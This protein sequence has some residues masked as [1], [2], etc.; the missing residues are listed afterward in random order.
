LPEY[1]EIPDSKLDSIQVLEKY[2]VKLVRGGEINALIGDTGR[3]LEE[4]NSADAAHA[5]MMSKKLELDPGLSRH[6][7]NAGRR[8]Y[9]MKLDPNQYVTDISNERDGG[10]DVY[11]SNFFNIVVRRHDV[12]LGYADPSAASYSRMDK[13]VV[14]RSID[15]RDTF[16]DADHLAAFLIRYE[17]VL[18]TFRNSCY[19]ELQADSVGDSFVSP[20]V[21]RLAGKYAETLAS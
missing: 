11:A 9:R 1:A 15:F 21:K 14:V 18:L 20:G 8:T 6:G 4:L 7:V 10:I 12:F 17:A 3:P 5:L 13:N 16:V 19:S 2:G